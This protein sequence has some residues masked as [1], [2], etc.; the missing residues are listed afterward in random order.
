MNMLSSCEVVDLTH[1]LAEGMPAHPE[2]SRYFHQLWNSYW[3]GD[4][5]VTYQI[6]LNEHSGTHVDAPA[7]FITDGNRNHT[8]IEELSP[9]ALWG[10][11]SVIDVREYAGAPTFDID[12]LERFE[13]VRGRIG[14]GDVVLFNTGWSRKWALRPGGRD[15]IRGWPGPT[16][17]LCR[18]LV[19]RNVRAVGC[20]NLGLDADGTVDCPA[21][22]LLL[23]SAIPIIENLSRLDQLP[24]RGGFFMAT[25]LLIQ[26][27][28]GS[29]IRALCLL[30]GGSENG[31]LQDAPFLGVDGVAGS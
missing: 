28:S 2:H 23:G 18:G 26:G 6:L 10:P 17:E 13:A 3:H 24:E 11:C 8:W 15:Y 7:H 25:P 19:D 31:D 1:S 14:A 22:V 21:H 12:V 27:G 5:S 30:P 29:P 20:D 9:M 16:E 4:K